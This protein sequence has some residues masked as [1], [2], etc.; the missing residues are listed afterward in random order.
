VVEKQQVV[1]VGVLEAEDALLKEVRLL[2]LKLDDR[3]APNQG[4]Q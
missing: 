2:S 1:L 4:C 3:Q